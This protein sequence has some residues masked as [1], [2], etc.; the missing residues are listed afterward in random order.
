VGDQP[1][2]DDRFLVLAPTGRDASLTCSLLERAGLIARSCADIDELCREASLGATALLVAEEVLVPRNAA[3]LAAL[4][5]E[6]PAWSDLPVLIFTGEGATIQA[7]RP[8]LDQLAPF[9]NVILLD[10]PIHPVTMVSAARAARRARRRQYD[11]RAEVRRQAEAVTQRDRFLAML[12]HELRNPLAAILLAVQ[13]MENSEHVPPHLAVVRRQGMIL[14][15]LVDDLLD[16]GRVTS[17]KVVLH[18]TVVELNQLLA[19]CIQSARHAID[20]TDLQVILRREKDDVT[21]SGDPVRLE[22]VFTNLLMNAIKYSSPGGR[23]T[24]TVKRDGERAMVCVRDRGV[25]I[26]SEML[27]RIFDLFVQVEG[28]I[29]RAQGGLGI[30]LTLV[31]SLVELHGGSIAAASEGLGKGSEFT[32]TLPVFVPRADDA[33]AARASSPAASAPVSYNVMVVED[34]PETRELTKILVETW[35]HHATA[36]RDGAEAL[37]RATAS[38]PDVMIIDIGLPVLN[39][40]ELARRIRERLGRNVFLIAVTGYGQPEDRRRALEAGFDTHCTKPVDPATLERLLS[41]PHP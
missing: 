34:Q 40:Y 36:A 22:Q 12:G 11:A 7:R 1:S 28:T 17:G 27:P 39:G 30:G 20:Q 41:R 19:R 38:P 25:G 18:R 31:R 29:D 21:V 2:A 24:I 23:I 10:R 16:V 8:T 5:G 6:Q 4:L 3:K 26:S 32:V 37:D 15:R 33:A 13:V 35:G 14:A 9:G